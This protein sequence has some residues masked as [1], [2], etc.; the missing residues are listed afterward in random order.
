[1]GFDLGN[2]DGED[3]QAKKEK[4]KKR[5]SAWYKKTDMNINRLGKSNRRKEGLP[6]DVMYDQYKTPSMSTGLKFLQAVSD[7][8]VH[9]GGKSNSNNNSKKNSN[10]SSSLNFDDVAISSR[11][12][13]SN[14]SS[15]KI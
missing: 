1:M 2:A 9:G 11:R 5:K 4:V 13:R 8:R 15:Q 10:V 7:L 3:E 12:W 6:M 14:A